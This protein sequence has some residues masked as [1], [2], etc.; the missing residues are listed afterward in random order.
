M[1]KLFVYSGI[2]GVVLNSNIII[3]E[4]HN[5]APEAYN[6]SSIPA[7]QKPAEDIEQKKAKTPKYV[8][9][10][11][12]LIN[13]MDKILGAGPYGLILQVRRETRKRLYGLS[14]KSD[15]RLGMYKYNGENHTATSLAKIES[16]YEMEYYSKKDYLIKNKTQYAEDE[17]NHEMETVEKE[18]A[19]RKKILRKILEEAKDDFL[20]LSEDYL[21]SARGTKEQTLTLIKESCEKRGVKNCF[22]L[23]WGE[24]E[25]GNETA[26]L[27]NEVV[28]FKEFAK[29]LYDLSNFLEDMAR[30]C[31]R[32]KA[33]FLEF[34][35]K[36]RK[37]KSAT[38]R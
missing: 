10:T 19:E 22:I 2:I 29:F 14:T 12:P 34:I 11:H 33:R 30:S 31:P 20:A 26:L 25:E 13:F 5:I 4:N 35:R 16:Q 6:I 24:A 7:M 38:P 3:T 8:I 36:N 32:S 15:K 23:K 18:Y 27:K 1:K 17:W 9:L 28:T 37:N 21:E